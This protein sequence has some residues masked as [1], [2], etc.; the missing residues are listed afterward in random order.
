MTAVTAA[1]VLDLRRNVTPEC[2]G[3][4]ITMRTLVRYTDHGETYDYPSEGELV[5]PTA[6]SS[7]S[8][9]PLAIPDL[10]STFT[11]L[12][13][14]E[15]HAHQASKLLAER[16]DI[17]DDI[18]RFDTSYHR[19]NHPEP[20]E[21][22]NLKGPWSPY[23]SRILQGPQALIPA[24]RRPCSPSSGS[25]SR[26]DTSRSSVGSSNGKD[27]IDTKASD[28]DQGL[29]SVPHCVAAGIP[30]YKKSSNE[31]AT[32]R[33]SRLEQECNRH[34][35]EI[36]DDA[37]N[38]WVIQP[39]EFD[40]RFRCPFAAFK[41]GWTTPCLLVSAGNLDGIR[42]HIGAHHRDVFWETLPCSSWDQIF[43]VCFPEADLGLCPSPYFDLR[44]VREKYKRL[45]SFQPD[46]IRPR[47]LHKESET[48]SGIASSDIEIKQE[49]DSSISPTA[50]C[51]AP[52]FQDV[53]ET[54]SSFQAILHIR[55]S[56]YLEKSYGRPFDG[57]SHGLWKTSSPYG[58]QNQRPNGA[59]ANGMPNLQSNPAGGSGGG[60]GLEQDDFGESD[61]EYDEGS[62]GD[63]RGRTHDKIYNSFPVWHL[64]CPL[65]RIGFPK[66]ETIPPEFQ[67]P[68][69]RRGRSFGG[70]RKLKDIRYHIK[71]NHTDI[72]S[73][74]KLKS[75]SH[76]NAKTWK[77]IFL[78]LFPD[79][80][81]TLKHPSKY[82]ESPTLYDQLASEYDCATQ[83]EALYRAVRDSRDLE[84]HPTTNN[85]NQ[86]GPQIHVQNYENHLPPT[87]NN[88]VPETASG[89][90]GHYQPDPQNGFFDDYPIGPDQGL[91][92][93][94]YMQF[95][96]P[97]QPLQSYQQQTFEPMNGPMFLNPG[98]MYP[99]FDAGSSLQ[100]MSLYQNQ[101][102]Q[103]S[104]HQDSHYSGGIPHHHG[105]DL[106]YFGA[107][108]SGQEIAHS[109]G[110]PTAEEVFTD[111]PDQGGHL[112]LSP[113]D[114]QAYIQSWSPPSFQDQNHWADHTQEDFFYTQD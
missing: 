107:V 88:P 110:Y 87:S 59:D 82:H 61:D 60:E 44:L 19:L 74:E 113:N 36:G 49:D 86:M 52:S 85:G 12:G 48:S 68:P 17:L 42:N 72:W 95:D 29:L 57:S 70:G 112:Q 8:E 18:Q 23:S 97:P 96:S 100:Q 25:S 101:E 108:F 31:A 64:G 4:T 33:I 37:S 3:V 26:S 21:V 1:T 22:A 53:P 81:D 41:A 109:G 83:R 15:T 65:Q 89:P 28:D 80:P 98:V 91:I 54:F 106:S 92:M 45:W 9:F 27:S 51:E 7:D 77:G 6:D 63:G 14:L 66:C 10:S 13:T 50:E 103:Y 43:K 76:P 39:R 93:P 34:I 105:Q 114:A 38:P 35:Q 24:W 75:I 11:A 73:K 62:D 16:T 94:P 78:K 46:K 102:Y 30:F 69:R 58:G 99:Q 84:L 104:E 40:S 79:W 20:P 71:N 90:Q 2:V 5:G 55:F 32:S 67:C 56:L 47:R 111:Y